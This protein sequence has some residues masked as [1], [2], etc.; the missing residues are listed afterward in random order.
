MS[1]SSVFAGLKPIRPEQIPGNADKRN[2]WQRW[3]DS[4]IGAF[5]EMDA[6]AVEVIEH[7]EGKNPKSIAAYLRKAS[8]RLSSDV[9]VSVLLSSDR[10][11]MEKKPVKIVDGCKIVDPFKPEKKRVK[12]PRSSAGLSKAVR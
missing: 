11:Y 3:A 6:A 8:A 5:L 2:E 12:M 4:T 10:I 9:A 1:S 7:P